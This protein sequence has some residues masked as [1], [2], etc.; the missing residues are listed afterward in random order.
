VGL[1]WALGDQGYDPL[2]EEDGRIL[3]IAFG[4]IWRQLHGGRHRG[5]P[6]RGELLPPRF[7]FSPPRLMFLPRFFFR[8][9]SRK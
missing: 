9:F 4:R 8:R 5:I 3:E 7:F 1:L 2:L 6:S